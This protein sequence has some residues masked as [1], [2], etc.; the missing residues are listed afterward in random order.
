[1]STS[2]NTNISEIHDKVSVHA[3]NDPSSYFKTCRKKALKL[4]IK[5][6]TKSWN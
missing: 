3:L 1:M 4:D 2:T 5:D 6:S